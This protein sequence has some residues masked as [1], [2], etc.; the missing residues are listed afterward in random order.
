MTYLLILA[1]TGFIAGA[2]N[3]AAGGGSFVTLP[4]LVFLGV[5]ALNANVSSTVALVPAA[6]ASAVAYRDDFKPF[7]P[8]SLRL[9]PIGMPR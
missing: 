6:L 5:P 3:A 1:A 4:V 2:M 9:L 8:V 7:G